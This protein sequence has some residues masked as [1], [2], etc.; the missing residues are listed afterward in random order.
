MKMGDRIRQMRIDA[1][2]TQE[3]LAEKLVMMNLFRSYRLRRP[4]SQKT[5]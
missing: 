1:G 5:L 4:G 3:E 2:M